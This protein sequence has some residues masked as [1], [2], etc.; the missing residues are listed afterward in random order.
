MVFYNLQ[1][2]LI[3]SFFFF[4]AP[5]KSWDSLTPLSAASLATHSASTTV[6]ALLQSLLSFHWSTRRW[7]KEW[8]ILRILKNDQE[9]FPTKK[10]RS[11][12]AGG[13]SGN[14]GFLN[15]F[16]LRNWHRPVNGRDTNFNA[17][18]AL[19]RGVQGDFLEKLAFVFIV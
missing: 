14:C 12:S 3:M 6:F 9:S 4:A 1:N 8:P 5:W 2:V 17:I 7:R 15:P 16:P 11:E 10:E 18:L 19:R 13:S